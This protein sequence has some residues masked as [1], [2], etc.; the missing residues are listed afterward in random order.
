[1]TMEV[2]AD[3]TKHGTATAM[4]IPGMAHTRKALHL[5]VNTQ[6]VS[7]PMRILRI[8]TVDD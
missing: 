7:R 6:S 3:V 5:G 8:G 2:I 4:G 1:M